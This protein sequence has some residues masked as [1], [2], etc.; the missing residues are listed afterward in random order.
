MFFNKLFE[1]KDETT[2]GN[3]RGC[4]TTSSTYSECLHNAGACEL[5]IA[6]GTNDCSAEYP[7][8]R[9]KCV[10]CDSA[11]GKC[12]TKQ[13]PELANQYSMYCK[14]V[15]DSCVVITRTGNYSFAQM[16]ASEMRENDKIYCNSNGGRCSFCAGA[17]N[18]NLKE[19]DTPG[20]TE[21]PP[22]TTT[23]PPATSRP[24]SGHQFYSNHL[25]LAI[26][27]I[28]SMLRLIT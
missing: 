6:G 23:K 19:M 1:F 5:C 14:N 2:G 4:V 13:E 22:N 3:Q 12:P 24:S 9:R 20:M 28:I 17:D 26:F 27:L 15:T 16:C 8:N 21:A 7:K 10:R 11:Y 25:L 18:C